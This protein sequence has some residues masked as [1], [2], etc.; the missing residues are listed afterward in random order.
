MQA[1]A[2]LRVGAKDCAVGTQGQATTPSVKE[3]GSVKRVPILGV[4][5]TAGRPLRVHE[6]QVLLHRH[7]LHGEG[8][9]HGSREK[10]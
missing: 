6:K 5:E 8:R 3:K 1:A 9:K 4:T 10:D 2:A 7:L